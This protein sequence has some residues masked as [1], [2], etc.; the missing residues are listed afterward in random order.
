MAKETLVEKQARL[1]VMAIAAAEVS[2]HYKITANAVGITEDTLMTWRKS[3]RN[4][5]DQLE[6]ARARFLNKQIAKA[7]PEFLLER[8][9]PEIFKQR[10]EQDITSKGEAIKTA[11]VRFVGEDEPDATK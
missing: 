4:F 1:K 8:L 3:D 2:Y 6:Q 9:E 11:L 7:K 10:S 5:S